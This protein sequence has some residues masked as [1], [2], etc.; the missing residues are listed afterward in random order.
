MQLLK[1]S[2]I[3]CPACLIMNSRYNQIQEKYKLNII[4]YDYDLHHEEVTQYQIGKI[5]PVIIIVDEKG[6]E[7]K[8]IVGELSLKKLEQQIEELL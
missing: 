7:I 1:F 3:W 2:A 8:R 4:E 5:L 6:Q